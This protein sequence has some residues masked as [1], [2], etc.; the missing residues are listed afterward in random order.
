[1]R[2]RGLAA[3]G[4]EIRAA[5]RVEVSV[6]IRVVRAAE[7]QADIPGVSLGA[8]RLRRSL[9]STVAR[10]VGKGA[11]TGQTGA[12]ATRTRARSVWKGPRIVLTKEPNMLT[13]VHTVW[14]VPR[15]TETRAQTADLASTAVTGTRAPRASHAA[16]RATSRL[17]RTVSKSATCTA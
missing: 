2:A 6:E 14:K 12:R 15:I 5:R 7:I 1:M 11:R 13:A 3:M 9:A 16:L 10:I 8:T 17:R 4:V